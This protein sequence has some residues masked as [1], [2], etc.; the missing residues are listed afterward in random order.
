MRAGYPSF[1]AD[2]HVN[3]AKILIAIFGFT[4]TSIILIQIHLIYAGIPRSVGVHLDSTFGSDK[5]D[6]IDEGVVF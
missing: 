3:L 4:T 6:Y 2:P 1:F 5:D